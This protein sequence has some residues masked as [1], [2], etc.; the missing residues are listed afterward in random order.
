MNSKLIARI[1]GDAYCDKHLLYGLTNFNDGFD[2]SRIKY[3]S[4]KDV[5]VVLERVK[6]LGIGIFGIEPWKN[7]CYYDCKV[8][9]SHTS[10]PT[11]ATWYMTCFEN[12]KKRGDN[13]VYAASYHIPKKL[14]SE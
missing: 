4:E 1:K 6:S 11:D 14:Y 12:F 3:F 7:G 10:D 13:I 9:E 2:D 8:Y 5:E